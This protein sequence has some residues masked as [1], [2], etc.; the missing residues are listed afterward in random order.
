MTLV[1]VPEEL[2]GMGNERCVTTGVLVA[3]ALAHGDMGQAVAIQ[4][5]TTYAA[6]A[7]SPNWMTGVS[8]KPHSMQSGGVGIST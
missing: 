6:I 5:T 4:I 2:G 8:K 1:G 7:R 3:E